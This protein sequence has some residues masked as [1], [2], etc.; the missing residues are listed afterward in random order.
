MEGIGALIKFAQVL[1]AN[2]DL[3]TGYCLFLY[4]VCNP[5]GVEAGTPFSSTGKDLNL[6]VLK[7]SSEPEAQILQ[8]ELSAKQFQGVIKLH[9]NREQ[10]RLQGLTRGETLTRYFLEPA[11]LPAIDLL[12]ANKLGG[13]QARDGNNDHYEGSGLQV[14]KE[15][16]TPF[17]II[18]EAPGQVAR[19]LREAALVAALRSILAEYQKFIAYAP[20]L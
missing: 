10:T 18:L 16:T 14:V 13:V 15:P 11:L 19:A 17:E 20:N 8:A 5:S 9:V 6:E 2:P 4:P 3:A 12:G 1:E 7:F